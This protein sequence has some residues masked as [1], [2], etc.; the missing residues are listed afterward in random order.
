MPMPRKIEISHRTIIFTILFLILLLFLYSIRDLIFEI[1]LA[2]LIMAILNPIVKKLS[3]YKIPQ[4][5]SVFIA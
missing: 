4:G 3:K 1:F 5:V 2:L